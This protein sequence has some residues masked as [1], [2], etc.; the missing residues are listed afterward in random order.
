MRIAN[1]MLGRGLGGI[2]QAFL[3]YSYSLN[4]VGHEVACVTH[5]A[6]AINDR[7]TQLNLNHVTLANM[8][9]WDPFAPGKLSTLL[10]TLRSDIVICHGNRA[11]VFAKKAVSGRI[12]IVG[13]THNYQ[14]RHIEGADAVFTITEDL[15]QIVI[16]DHGFYPEAVFH[17]PNMVR[18]EKGLI[19]PTWQ[20]PPVIGTL[21]RMV[22]KK[23]FDVYLH[24]LAELKQAGF[25]FRAVLGGAGEEE[26]ALKQLAA[27]LGLMETVHF[28]GWVTDP[29]TFLGS[30]DIFCL[31]SHHEPFGIVL[32]EAMAAKLPVIS[33]DA[34]GPREI[35]ASP[36][37]GVLV[38]RGDATAMAHALGHIL[39]DESAARTMA[40]EGY[41]HVR[42]TYE[43]E[44]VATYMGEVLQH[45]ILHYH[46]IAAAS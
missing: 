7:V 23:G 35:L 21:G 3:D 32:L 8:G 12:P 29:M 16:R 5:P 2:E 41:R 39:N 34:E 36:E 38:P 28:T 30:I 10:S 1:I 45:I 15:R 18:I 24:A 42:N 31:P 22:A 19:R 17:M 33:T 43:M 13:V 40:S 11:L 37:H 20:Q 26:K 9:P 6:A 14:L 46:P 4:Q 44:R 25:E 27:S